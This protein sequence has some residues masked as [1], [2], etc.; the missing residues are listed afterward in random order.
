MKIN[1]FN[2]FIVEKVYLSKTIFNKYNLIVDPNSK[3]G[4]FNLDVRGFGDLKVEIQKYGSDEDNMFIIREPNVK[5]TSDLGEVNIF[6]NIATDLIYI[7]NKN[8]LDYTFKLVEV[9]SER[10]MGLYGLIKCDKDITIEGLERLSQSTKII[11]AKVTDKEEVDKLV[12]KTASGGI[13]SEK[14]E[15]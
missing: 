6:K 4:Y 5:L 7:L 1:R 2:E 10:N 9:K 14:F 15:K 8:K 12:Y 3:V 11:N 13:S